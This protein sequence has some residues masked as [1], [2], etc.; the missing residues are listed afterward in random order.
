MAPV[1]L[2][3]WSPLFD[4]EREQIGARPLWVRLL[5]LPLQYWCEE[6]FINIGNAL[7]TYFDHDH[8]F[9]ES[10]NRTLACVMVHLDTR[11][12][13][14][15]NITLQ[16]GN[17]CRIQIL[18]YEGVLF[19]C[20]WCHKV[21]HLYKDCPLNRKTKN[22]P[23]V[24]PIPSRVNSSAVS[25]PSPSSPTSSTI[26]PPLK[27]GVDGHGPSSL[28]MTRACA[29][30]EAAQVS[31]IS[32]NRSSSSYENISSFVVSSAQISLAH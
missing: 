26:S 4:P 18:D 23:K 21:G 31:G 14:E 22:S 24:T 32:L 12:G 2:K 11:E 7:R 29:A 13:L 15:E 27:T 19:H 1:L 30:T 5:G 9:I 3:H 25:R 28:P 20:R 8:T 10:K 16:W 17:Y 6:V